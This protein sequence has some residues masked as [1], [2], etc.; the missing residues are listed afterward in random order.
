MPVKTRLRGGDWF[1]PTYIALWRR[2]S[3]GRKTDT[4]ARGR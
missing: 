3:A 2:P 4:H 1:K